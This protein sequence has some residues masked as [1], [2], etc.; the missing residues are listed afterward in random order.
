MD[1]HG[2]I[3][4][5]KAEPALRDAIATDQKRVIPE[6]EADS[7]TPDK[8]RLLATG[9]QAS[10]TAFCIS[11]LYIL[12]TMSREIDI[13]EVAKRNH[14]GECWV[15]ING[16]VYDVT[17]FVQSH[18]G[19]A[20]SILQYA[21]KDA[22]EEYEPI[23][24]P[25]TLETSLPKEKCLGQVS[26]AQRLSTLPEP[27][28]Q[29][30]VQTKHKPISTC[31][32][33]F[34]FEE[35]ARSRL[36]TRAWIYYSS[37]SEDSLTFSSNRQD[38]QSLGFRPRVMRN[39]HTVRTNRAM[40]GHR[41]TLP[42]FI[43]PAALARLGH[44]DGELCLARGAVRW[45][46]PY[47]VSTA[48]STSF[49]DL[50]NCVQSEQKKQPGGT[51][52]FQLYVKKER[53]ET[54]ALIHQARSLGY[55]ALLVTVDTAAVAPREEDDRYKLELAAQSGDPVT[56]MFTAKVLTEGEQPAYRAPYSVKLKWRDLEWIRAAW[57]NA[58]PIALKGIATA[59][60]ALLACNAGIDCIYLSN[61]GGR[62]LDGSPSALR[63]L[64]EIRQSCPL[65][66]ERC[67]ILLDGGVRR[68]SDVI[69]ALCLGAAG[70]GLGRPFMFA[71]SAY[72]TEGVLRAIQM[73]DHEIQTTMRLLGV[74]S[75][76]E[77]GPQYVNTWALARTLQSYHE[78]KGTFLES[79]KL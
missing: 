65:V 35:V 18:P 49:E 29:G 22:T 28:P 9:Q 51:L 13:D 59:E 58:G 48:S 10:V 47:A 31:V 75:L 12:S 20:A 7:P 46:I 64:L 60:D 68:G 16:F 57:N 72:G 30:K 3:T 63:T 74:S 36:S 71:L 5:I 2:W 43:A 40:L 23:H 76:D 1:S 56:E 19:G 6:A 70:V 69:K 32:N 21:G 25:G 45:N 38:W 67:A 73:M 11:Q 33:L 15:I 27:Q 14:A 44:P 77:L 39:V 54:E 42:I 24:P 50:A 66:L 26:L 17:D 41:S 61:H 79:S 34:D 53:S 4:G 8:F 52:W 78:H 55:S 37:S 62:Q